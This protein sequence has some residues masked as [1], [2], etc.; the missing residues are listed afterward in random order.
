MSYLSRV[1]LPGLL[2]I[3]AITISP[4]IIQEIYSQE[5]LLLLNNGLISTATNDYQISSNFEI[6]VFHDGELIR[7][8]GITASGYPYYV[9][10][11]M[12]DGDAELRGK[13]FINGK[14][15]SIVNK[16]SYIQESESEPEQESVAEMLILIDHTSFGYYTQSYNVI[17]KVFDALQN[18][19]KVFEHN[20]GLL[21]GIDI[22]IILTDPDGNVFRTYNGTTNALGYFDERFQ[23]KY[24]D[25]IGQ[26]NVTVIAD[27]GINKIAKQY[28]TSYKGYHPYYT[29]SDNPP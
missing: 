18:P 28:D 4:L 10:Q 20:S 16:V 13:I 24:A 2:G 3:L 6:R 15:F 1:I 26:Y 9:Y 5:E 22:Q 19:L 23:W 27:D 14:M 8:K 12:I 21:E 11:K 7:I 25:P 17:A 29:S